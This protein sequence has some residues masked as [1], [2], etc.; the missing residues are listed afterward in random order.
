MFKKN[1]ATYKAAQ[2]TSSASESSP[3]ELII[4]LLEKACSSVLRAKLIVSEN[5]LDAPD[6]DERLT[7]T[8]EYFTAI[9]KALEIAMALRAVVDL[10]KGG[11]LATQLL[12][13]Y[14]AIIRGLNE[15]RKDK[16]VPA[17]EKIYEAF[18][19]MKDAWL[20]VRSM[21]IKQAV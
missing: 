5:K 20:T 10:E 9:A 6:L 16:S 3:E 7:A 4:L 15:A 18:S 19:E 2:N 13:T 17:F 21:N 14:D 1:A 11:A 8:E 12:V